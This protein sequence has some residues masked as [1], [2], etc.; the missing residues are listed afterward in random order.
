MTDVQYRAQQTWEPMTDRT[1]ELLGAHADTGG[2]RTRTHAHTHHTPHPHTNTHTMHTH[3]HHACTHAAD[4]RRR[5]QAHKRSVFISRQRCVKARR[6]P[7]CPGRAAHPRAPGWLLAPAAGC[8]RERRAP[9]LPAGPGWARAGRAPLSSLGRCPRRRGRRRGAAWLGASAPPRR[10]GQPRP[11]EGAA[12]SA[13]GG[14]H[15]VWHETGTCVGAGSRT[16]AR[17]A[18]FAPG[19]AAG[20]L[21]VRPRGLRGPSPTFTGMPGSGRRCR[22]PLPRSRASGR[23]CPSQA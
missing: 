10:P 7:L 14:A 5:P 17:R 15:C 2:Q 23:S 6:P 3:I 8:A 16:L 22:H 21:H 19:E 11:R 20:H 1:R 18:R 12:G 9:S 13:A 4:T